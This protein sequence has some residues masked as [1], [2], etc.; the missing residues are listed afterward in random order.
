MLKKLTAVI[1]TLLSFCCIF[2]GCG[3]DDEY[4][5]NEDN[6]FLVMTNMQYYPEGYEGCNIE[7]DCFTYNLT[8]VNGNVY[9]CGVRKCSAGY[10]C[11]CGQDTIIGFILNYDGE[12][13]EP[14]NQSED[15]NEKTWI[16]LKGKINGTNKTRI[17]INSYKPDGTI[18]QGKTEF[19]EF[20]SFNVEELTLIEDY[21]NLNY[22]VTK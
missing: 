5:L 3:G 18:D 19:I 6:F 15:T 17:E 13:P 8:D 12:I 20:L 7:F 14:I 16:H 1:I 11:T 21:T 10:G 2:M 9:T 4:I 22:Y